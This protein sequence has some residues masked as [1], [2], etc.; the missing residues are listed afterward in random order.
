MSIDATDVQPR[1]RRLV[2]ALGLV[3]RSG[4]TSNVANDSAIRRAFVTIP[5]E[6]VATLNATPYELVPAPGAGRYIEVLTIHWWLDFGTEAYDAAAAGDTLNAKYTDGSGAAV[7]D[8]VAGDAI[9][10]AAADYHTLV[11]GV[12]EVIP[13]AN[14]AIVAHIATG[15]WYAAAGDSP[16]KAEII[17][18]DRKL[19]P[20]V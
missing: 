14:A 15:E 13:V 6:D 7:V 10:A 20:T 4:E 19:E 17:Y 11:K 8:A 3:L 12:P 18:I 9:G 16:L 2:G 1:F 5:A